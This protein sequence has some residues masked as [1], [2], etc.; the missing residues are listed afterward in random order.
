[1]HRCNESLVKMIKKLEYG[2]NP[3]GPKEQYVHTGSAQLCGS[4]NSDVQQLCSVDV[5]VM[6]PADG[7]YIRPYFMI[8]LI[9]I[10]YNKQSNLVLHF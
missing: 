7:K 10:L 1:M 8:Y 3:P 5:T 9:I 4:H 6:S 2:W